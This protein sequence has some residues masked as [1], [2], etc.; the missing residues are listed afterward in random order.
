M[1]FVHLESG[2]RKQNAAQ[3][4]EYLQEELTPQTLFPTKT[5]NCQ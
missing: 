3:T 5:S 2:G 4:E 1:A